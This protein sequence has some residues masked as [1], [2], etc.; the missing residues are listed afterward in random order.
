MVIFS[1]GP[2]GGRNLVQARP[3]RARKQILS[4]IYY[5]ESVKDE[6]PSV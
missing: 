1:T 6:V 2:E 4:N 3:E 5:E